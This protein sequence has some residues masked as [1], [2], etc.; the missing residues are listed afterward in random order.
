MSDIKSKIREIEAEIIAITGIENDDDNGWVEDKEILRRVETLL[1]HRSE[2]LNDAF[3]MTD[4]SL[5]RLRQVNELLTSLTKQAY[6]RVNEV[7]YFL[8]AY[9]TQYEGEDSATECILQF[10]YISE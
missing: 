2:L 4:R 10:I 6:D 9:M 1:K 7:N 8:D 3:Q 5:A